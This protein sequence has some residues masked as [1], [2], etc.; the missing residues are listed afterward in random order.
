MKSKDSVEDKTAD[1]SDQAPY[2]GREVLIECNGERH[3]ASQDASGKWWTI[4][5]RKEFQGLVKVVQ[6]IV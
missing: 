4:S 6:V 1:Q 3:L 5:R 2:L